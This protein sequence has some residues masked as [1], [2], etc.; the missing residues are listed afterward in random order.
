M[1]ERGLYYA[2]TTVLNYKMALMDG[3]E[4]L[5]LIEQRKTWLACDFYKEM[6]ALGKEAY[7]IETSDFYYPL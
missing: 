6:A 2:R 4:H 5:V 7:S 3:E 1:Y